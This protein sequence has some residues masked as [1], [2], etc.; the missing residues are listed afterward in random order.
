MPPAE[1]APTPAPAVAS[2]GSYPNLEVDC[3][4]SEAIRRLPSDWEAACGVRPLAVYTYV[5]GEHEG[6]CYRE[7]GWERCAE[8][9]SGRPPGP[10]RRAT[11][12]KAVWVRPLDS[13]WRDELGRAP[14][15]TLGSTAPI[16]VD[17]KTDWADI[18]Y[19]H[20]VHVDGRVRQRIAAM[21]RFWEA[22]PGASIPEIFPVRAERT[23]AYRLLSN[24]RGKME[25]IL[26]GHPEATVERFR[27]EPVVLAIQD[28]TTLN[29]GGHTATEGLV[30]ISG[31]SG[32][33]GFWP[34][35]A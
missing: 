23:A 4:L 8:R 29:Y 15:R 11:T 20:G 3:A 19:G 6:A 2:D 5:D 33:Q 24:P 7:A 26:A 28:T 16:H 13:D 1:P 31:G 35:L 25:D 10:G 21:G 27:L 30:S 32:T 14:D 9:T 34:M 17:G 18:E 22:S 12:P